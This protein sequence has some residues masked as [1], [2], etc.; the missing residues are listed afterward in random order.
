MKK[1]F[2]L[3][4]LFL[5]TL[6]TI[7]AQTSSEITGD[8]VIE[9]NLENV[10]VTVSGK[11][12]LHLTAA[13]DALINSN[14]YLNSVDS[15][16]FFDNIRP[17][18]VVNKYAS[19]IFINN[20]PFNHKVNGRIS[21]YKHGTLVIPHNGGE[22][23]E[24]LEVFQ[25]ANFSGASNKLNLYTF[26]NSLGEFDN[27]I[28]SFKLKRGYMAVLANAPDGMGYSR[29]FIAD[30]EDLEIELL[31]TELHDKV[32]FIRVSYWQYPSKKGLCGKLRETNTETGVT[33]GENQLNLTESTWYYSWGDDSPDF[34]DY[35]FVTMKWGG[36]STDTNLESKVVNHFL[37]YNEPDAENQSNLTVERAIELWP[38]IQKSG[39]RL[40]S[41]SPVNPTANNDWLGRFMAKADSL[42]YRVDYIALHT[43]WEQAPERWYERLK[44]TYDRYKRPIW[45]T[46]GHTKSGYANDWQPGD[47]ETP[48][49]TTRLGRL[50]EVVKMLDTIPWVERYS[51][52]NWHDE[53]GYVFVHGDYSETVNNQ[54]LTPMGEFYRDNKAP[55]FY[56]SEEE[57]IQEWKLNYGIEL[58]KE[59]LPNNT[60]V[61]LSWSPIDDELVT[62]TLERKLA[63][64][65]EF[66]ELASFENTYTYSEDIIDGAS[67]R[68][69]LTLLTDGTTKDSNEII[70]N[71]DALPEAPVLLGEA[72]S[73]KII[74]LTW[75]PV[76]GSRYYSLERSITIDSG[77][78]I[79]ATNLEEL[80]FTDDNLDENTTYYYRLTATN[81][82]GTS[83][84]SIPFEITT[85]ALQIP[86][87]VSGVITEIGNAKV[88][89]DWD[90]LY[91]ANYAVK[92]SESPSGPFTVI[93][94]ELT[95]TVFFDTGLTNGTTYYY[96][97]SAY[98]AAG[99][100]QD[101]ESVEATPYVGPVALWNFNE[102]QG[103]TSI[104][105]INNQTAT[106]NSWNSQG[107][108]GAGAYFDGSN[109]SYVT[110]PSGIFQNIE[111]FTIS[112]WVNLQDVAEDARL[113]DFRRE[114]RIYMEMIM[115]VTG[116]G[117]LSFEIRNYANINK[118]LVDYIVPTNEWIHLAVT[119]KAGFTS[120]YING[121]LKGTMQ[122]NLNPSGMGITTMN[123]L[124]KPFNENRPNLTG[125]IDDFHIYEI[126]L[127][128]ENIL[129]I[130]NEAP[131]VLSTEDNLSNYFQNDIKVY[132]NPASEQLFFSGKLLS[133][134][135]IV[136][137]LYNINGQIIKKKVIEKGSREESLNVSEISNGL[138]FLKISTATSSK[139]RKIIIN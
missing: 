5:L 132:P 95:D 29:V 6:S 88:R 24:A 98:N 16:L 23:F 67:Y 69:K 38:S 120:L 83:E 134:S 130:M 135:K 52:Y 114:R 136:A 68:V 53:G 3:F 89:L 39:L 77:Y 22:N 48:Q 110:M 106:L 96:M 27:S 139:T 119:Q 10:N 33:Q 37:G 70:V 41:P 2:T 99:D 55:Y 74:D 12:D 75:E 109:N 117:V 21:V 49:Q 25:D 42:N 123:Y 43:Y 17:S 133:E 116:G 90:L 8:L 84:F 71:A 82:A 126:G 103:A 128:Q 63:S 131:L 36:G 66:S 76:N 32:S 58:S 101:S 79:I 35:E 113:F 81:Y 11:T 127:S 97:I 30:S 7:N 108:N 85:K 78:E 92:R 86:V 104:D 137:E 80:E 122:S 51:F 121:E 105:K 59:I 4:T 102:G 91:D 60:Q 20:V 31:P 45:I 112:T 93:A 115:D 18:D 100:G 57:Y 94:D 50:R 64:E 1:N 14:V 46:E 107:K 47:P 13:D 73:T 62:F 72:I 44:E 19:N 124:N 28:S 54:I 118:I 40:G 15:W 65:T 87:Q 111:D 26:H 9:E 56:A 138:Y 34:L 129:N 61:N 125:T